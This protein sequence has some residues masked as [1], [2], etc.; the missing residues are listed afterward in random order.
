[1]RRLCGAALARLAQAG[2]LQG[3]RVQAESQAFGQLPNLGFDIT[4]IHRHHPIAG[5]A[6]QVMVVPLVA[7]RVPVATFHVHARQHAVPLQQ[8]ERPIH[9]RATNSL[10]MQ[11]IRERLRIDHTILSD[12][13]ADDRL[14]RTCHTLAR[15]GE[16][17]QQ[18]VGAGQVPA[19][20]CCP[21]CHVSER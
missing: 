19:T 14:A 12:Q 15:L 2:K 5:G 16:S 20:R 4:G 21:Y 11:L 1:M 7:Q 3:V 9:R 8:V 13:R 10:R 18:P 17:P 6:Q